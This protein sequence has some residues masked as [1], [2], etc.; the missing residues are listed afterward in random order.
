MIDSS[1]THYGSL[2]STPGAGTATLALC[3]SDSSSSSF[4]ASSNFALGREDA[5]VAAGA[6]SAEGAWS[7]AKVGGASASGSL[8][9]VPLRF[10]AILSRA[11]RSSPCKALAAAL[12]LISR[13]ELKNSHIGRQRTMARSRSTMRLCAPTEIPSISLSKS[14]ASADSNQLQLRYSRSSRCCGCT[15]F[16]T[17]ST[18]RIPSST[19]TAPLGIAAFKNRF[20]DTSTAFSPSP[21]NVSS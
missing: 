15:H 18:R 14:Q 4:R 2:L 6:S 13:L 5:S 20:F 16:F 21:R 3:C 10:A 7:G 17:L 1:I 11:R 19:S 9:S 12:L 8:P